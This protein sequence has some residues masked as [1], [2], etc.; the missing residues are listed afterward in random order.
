ME[1]I[2]TKV[3]R[4]CILKLFSVVLKASFIEK[5][6]SLTVAWNKL[7][8]CLFYFVHLP[9]NDNQYCIYTVICPLS[10]MCIIHKI[11]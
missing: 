9:S 7:I 8:L 10:A 11:C 5:V 4:D 3:W 1:G 6:F 2:H